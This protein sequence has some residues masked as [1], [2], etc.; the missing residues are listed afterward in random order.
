MNLQQLEFESTQKCF[1]PFRFQFVDDP[2]S[3]RGLTPKSPIQ[4]IKT[5]QSG[6]YSPN[7]A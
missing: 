3:G 7:S 1:N 5:P 6:G 2:A 4:A